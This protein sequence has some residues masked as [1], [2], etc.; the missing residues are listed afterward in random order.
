MTNNMNS[1]AL[2][3]STFY[4]AWQQNNSCTCQTSSG[5]FHQS[6]V[7]WIGD[8]QI[9]VCTAFFQIVGMELMGGVIRPEDAALRELE[10]ED[11]A[12]RGRQPSAA[13]GKAQSWQRLV[14]NS[15]S[16]SYRSKL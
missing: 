15:D 2:I 5:E 16:I 6:K 13:L 3:F 10:S 8:Q 11:C 1:N 12:I 9:C 4:P 7:R 14:Q